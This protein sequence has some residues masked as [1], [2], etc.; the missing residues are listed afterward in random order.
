MSLVVGTVARA[1]SEPPAAA[2]TSLNQ[3][4]SPSTLISEPDVLATP[5]VNYLYSSGIGSN[6][7]LPVRSYT[8][9]GHWRT[10][11]DALPKPPTW[12]APNASVWSPD[13]RKV[14]SEYVMWFSALTARA[15]AG[16]PAR[17]LRCLG[18]ATSSSPMGPFR[19]S[20]T[21]P[22]LCQYADYGDIDPR[23]VVVDGHEY[24]MWKSNDNTGPSPTA[25]TVLYSQELAANGTTLKGAPVELM[26]NTQPWEGQVVES[27]DMV[28]EAGK[29]FL[30]FSSTNGPATSAAGIGVAICPQGP[31]AACDNSSSGPWLGS[32]T[33][34]AG[35]CEESLFQQNGATWLL[36]T[37]R[38]NYYRGAYP[39]LAVSRV[40]FGPHLPYVAS[41]DGSEPNP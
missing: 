2:N 4:Y 26:Q 5:S 1:D 10:T 13:V 33:N 12:A 21:Q 27:P 20:A 41:F 24:L 11:A 38:A 28:E 32:N 31:K 30:F 40:G 7:H 37:P 14:G 8:K 22:Q 29:F 35:P 9:I 19:S 6:P 3:I 39:V 15:P 25:P 34:G 23:T 16:A 36:Y 17:H 18:W